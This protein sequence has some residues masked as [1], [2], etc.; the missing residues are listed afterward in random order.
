MRYEFKQRFARSFK[1]LTPAEKQAVNSALDVLFNYFDK[2][3]ELP[4]GLGLKNIGNNYWEIRAGIKLRVLF[5]FADCIT[6]L[7][8]GNHD[9]V[10]RFVNE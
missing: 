4:A 2:K 5:E 6:F 1:K 7:F 3:I 8:V 10:K 9:D